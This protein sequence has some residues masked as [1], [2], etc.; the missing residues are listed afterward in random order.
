MGSQFTHKIWLITGTSTGLGWELAISA[1]SRGDNV[2]A[3][4]RSTETI[5]E[6]KE[7]YPRTCIILPLD[8]TD[9]FFNLSN[10]V[11]KAL[12]IWGRI[13]VLVHNAELGIVS[14]VEE[15][16]VE[17]LLEVYKTN[18]FGVANVTNAVLPCMRQRRN[19]TI[20]I[21]GNRSGW[22]TNLTVTL[23]NSSKAAVHAIGD[24]LTEELRPQGIRVL[25][26]VP[27]DMRTS[28]KVKFRSLGNIALDF[29][30]PDVA[31]GEILEY[32]EIRNATRENILAIQGKQPGDVTKAANVIVDVVRK[33]GLAEG[34]PWEGTLYLGSDAKR[35]VL[36]KCHE[37]LKTLAEWGDVA[38]SIDF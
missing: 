3:T 28:S 20:V 29:P 17:G 23:Y 7:L 24:A 30:S 32:A 10:T 14:A 4:A 37:T 18:V 22:C 34:R 26:V 35:D 31:S 33:E 2:I 6:L 16:G 1:L 27:G 8:V 9:T 11:K 25:T 19:G 13:D 12:S 36:G 21:I 38:K 5:E 15:A